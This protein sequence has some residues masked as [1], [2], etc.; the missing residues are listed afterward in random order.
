[1]AHHA[2]KR[3]A[4]IVDRE[5]VHIDEGEGGLWLTLLAQPKPNLARTVRGLAVD[6]SV[7]APVEAA[8]TMHCTAHR[9]RHRY[10]QRR[11]HTHIDR[12]ARIVKTTREA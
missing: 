3:H 9:V 4:D 1:M 6:E 11:F 12:A 8:S 5:R 7:V 2:L 10:P